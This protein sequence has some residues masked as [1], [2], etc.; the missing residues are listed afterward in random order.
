[1]TVQ[2]SNDADMLALWLNQYRLDSVGRTNTGLA[3]VSDLR[4]F[5]A[6]TTKP[7]R[8]LT[9]RDLQDFAATLT[10]LSEATQCRRLSAIKSLIA[11]GHR[12]GYLPYNVGAPIRLPSIK[13]TLA[14]R[15]MTE[16]QVQRLLWHADSPGRRGRLIKRN[17][18]ILRLLYIAGLRISEVCGL[19]WRDLVAR[20]DSGQA[21]VFGKGG[22]TR[23]ILLPPAMWSRLEALRE[24]AKPDDPVFH[25]SRGCALSRAMV[26]LIVKAAVKRAKL[27]SSVSAHYLRHSHASHALDRGAP[28]HVVQTTL[29]H[30]SLTTTTRY[31]HARPG[32]SSSKYLAA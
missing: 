1:M 31:T 15:I 6:F 4:A 29:G 24:A 8:Q 14:E 21:T 17:A 10:A 20:D 13:D 25:S 19:C 32:D 9:V 30:A 28:V 27:P 11:F 16:E 3:Y 23:V 12:V 7:L 22:K 18:A 2:A 5:Q 26:H